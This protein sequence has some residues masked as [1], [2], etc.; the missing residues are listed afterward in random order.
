VL[1]QYFSFPFSISIFR[2]YI[3]GKYYLKTKNAFIRVLTF[4]NL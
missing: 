3:F 4:E 1:A 2:A